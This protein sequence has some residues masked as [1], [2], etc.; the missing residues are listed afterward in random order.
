VKRVYGLVIILAALSLACNIQTLR[1][2]AAPPSPTS[3]QPPPTDPP[4][5]TTPTPLPTPT[6]QPTPTPLP[7]ARIALGDQAAF[8]GDWDSALA[9]YQAALALSDDAAVQAAAWLGQGKVYLARGDPT[10]ALAPLR[11]FLDA[12]PD[13]PR[14][15][16]AYFLL[17]SAYEALS[18]YQDAAEAYQSYLVL[19]PG[20]LDSYLNERRGDLLL[21]GGDVN[22]ALEAYQL[23][24]QPPRLGST[25]D[26]QI[27]IARAYALQGD[28]ATAL[29]V[30]GDVY[31]QSSSDL[32][33]A[34]AAYL[35]GQAYVNSGQTE[36]GY[37]AYLDAV[38]N[39]PKYY[40]AY[41]SLVELVT[42]GYPVDELQRGIVDYYARQYGV[43]LQALDR[44]LAASPTE[45]ATA[46][47]YRGLVLLALQDY[48][49]AI[50]MWDQVIQNFPDSEYWDDAHE[51]KA[52]TLWAYLGQ[53]NDA[54]DVLLGF[55]QSA[56]GHPRAGEFLFNAAQIAERAGSLEEAANLWRRAG[57]EYP[58][59]GFSHRAYF[60]AGIAG[61]R[62]GDYTAAL[63]DFLRAQAAASSAFERSAA[64]L[65]IGK[66]YQASGN[67]EVAQS[68]WQQT[69]LLDP[70]GYYSERAR[71]LMANRPPFT[72]PASYD[73]GRDWQA[74]KIEAEAWLR[75]TFNVP[76]G[77]DLSS[78]GELSDDSRF[79]RGRELWQLGLYSEASQEFESLRL[80]L[81]A[82]PVNSYRLAN[83]LLDLNMYRTAILCA[84]QVLNAAGLDD[85]ATLTAPVYFS[86]VRFG[87]YYA[88]LV[89]PAAQEHGFHP[90]FVWS[91]IRQESLFEK[92]IR[93]SASARGLMQIIPSTGRE[94]AARLGLTESYTDGDL[95]R[96]LVNITFGLEY[97]S[98]QLSYLDGNLYA[99]LAAYNAGPGNALEWKKLAPDDLDLYLEVIRWQE[100]RLY[101]Q[102]IY[103]NFVIYRKIYERTP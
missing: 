48:L 42:A 33:K 23:A 100:P 18:R 7:E 79:Q 69:S 71:D 65:W 15:A 60:L 38:M 68:A 81:Q 75:Q 8:N 92:S 70:T 25:L 19:R 59:A 99:A 2:I 35:M 41:L 85:A 14:R 10:S 82:D 43:A 28:H 80:S 22:A 94:I 32:Y 3:T 64:G 83:F 36:Q 21:A 88:D 31:N 11:Q 101:I 66:V 9:S 102:R 44:Y 50:D 5:T 37:N 61:Y 24:L 49:G 34:R 78:P 26:L 6:P 63:D 52:Y 98:T 51:E 73:L 91:M 97:L 17:G 96:P 47:Y 12:Q 62:R 29:V 103:E 74:E 56:A 54:K 13:S 76:T 87:T 55:V 89:I 4:P 39:F 77:I 53:Y 90:F 46:W 84:R 57:T 72:P 67:A 1:D 93:S 45:P 20:I 27:K 95:D 86:H 16:E 58:G 40:D 30:L